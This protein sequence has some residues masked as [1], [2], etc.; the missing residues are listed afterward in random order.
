VPPP[1]PPAPQPRDCDVWKPGSI[2]DGTGKCP[3]PEGTVAGTP[4]GG[5]GGGKHHQQAAAS[6]DGVGADGSLAPPPMPN[7]NAAVSSGVACIEKN[8]TPLAGAKVA[9]PA[10]P[11]CGFWCHNAGW[12]IALTAGVVGLGVY[13]WWEHK[14]NSSSASS[15]P[16]AVQT[17]P[18]VTY[19]PPS[20]TLTTVTAPASTTTVSGGTTSTTT[21]TTP[22]T[23]TQGSTGISTSVSGGASR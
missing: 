11:Q 6:D 21:V 10:A 9:A 22:T 16:A 2:D 14:H 5:P 7:G 18:T 13:F 15:I 3:C 8:R 20:S 12:I 19:P 17:L 1:P 23:T 4:S